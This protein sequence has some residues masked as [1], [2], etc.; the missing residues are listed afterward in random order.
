MFLFCVGTFDNEFSGRVAVDCVVHLVLDF[1]EES[2]GCG[3]IF[4]VVD[5]RGV[6]VRNLLIEAAFA[7]ADFPNFL[8]EMLKV[9]DIQ[10]GPFSILCLSMT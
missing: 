3:S 8:Q 9:I 1:L 4:V 6:D 2:A 10:E 7:Q 5:G